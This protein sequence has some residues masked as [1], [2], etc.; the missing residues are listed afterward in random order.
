[1]S[2]TNEIHTAGVGPDALAQ[3]P[4]KG[5]GGQ[6]A[7]QRM[8]WDENVV[9]V[10][11]RQIP[12]QYTQQMFLQEVIDRGFEGL[13]DFLYLPFDFR[14]NN[15]GYGFVSF[16]EPEHAIAFRDAM[17][18]VYLLE[19]SKQEGKALRIHPASLQGYEANCKHFANTKTGTEADPRFSPLFFPG[20]RASLSTGSTDSV[21]VVGV[22]SGA[23]AP[24][25]SGSSNARS[26][27]EQTHTAAQKKT[28]SAGADAAVTA[29]AS[30]PIDADEA[31]ASAPWDDSVVT[32]MIRQIPRY[33]TQHMFLLEVNA[34]GFEGKFDFL[35]LPF[36]SRKLINIGY[37]FVSFTEPLYARMFRE[38]FDGI[39]LGGN[40]PQHGGGKPLR[41][42]PASVQGYAANYERFAATKLHQKQDLLF[43]PLFF[44]GG[45]QTISA[46]CQLPERA[47]VKQDMLLK[48][49]AEAAYKNRVVA[50]SKANKPHAQ[51]VG[52]RSQAAFG[53][54]GA[55]M[56]SMATPA[57]S[58]P[59][60]EPM[61]IQ[62]PTRSPALVPGV[63]PALGGLGG[64]PMSQFDAQNAALIS[65]E[66]LGQPLGHGA[67]LG[68]EFVT[69]AQ[70]AA[71]LAV[72]QSNLKS[73]SD[74]LANALSALIALNQA[75]GSGQLPLA[76]ELG[77]AGNPLTA[78][79]YNALAAQY[80]GLTGAGYDKGSTDPAYIGLAPQ[81][82]GA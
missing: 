78:S 38:V 1:M 46:Q 25:G 49:K 34:K 23:P 7:S 22:G 14:K 75:T 18:G 40:E 67:P 74:S 71:A 10:M 69:P 54:H 29:S 72:T 37:G 60:Q 77:A 11:V 66:L 50:K 8:Q 36:D 62:T 5:R 20:G 55:S 51:M 4:R 9:T 3:I 64:W 26:E 32:L 30:A 61:F 52:E 59:G 15:V 48:A 39:V 56:P 68:A 27:G 21:S 17:D 44:P 53:Q 63:S 76:K 80:A 79:G 2:G 12:R 47:P 33:Y 31:A 73:L 16:L 41:V 28:P 45:Q 13:F 43:S 42:H 81:A 65:Q 24:K 19:K 6:E 58:I 82:M 57:K 70:Q 35:Y